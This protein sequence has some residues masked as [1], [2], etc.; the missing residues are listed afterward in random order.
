MQMLGSEC[1]EQLIRSFLTTLVKVRVSA[2]NASIASEEMGWDADDWTDNLTGREEQARH[3]SVPRQ[4]DEASG[5]KGEITD[6]AGTELPKGL[7]KEK[8]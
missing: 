7:W 3:K 5:L 8:R 4:G 1:W 2:V 6:Q